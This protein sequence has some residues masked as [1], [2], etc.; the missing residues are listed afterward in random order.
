MSKRIAV[1]VFPG[2]NSECETVRILAQCG[3][4]AHLV[5]WSRASLLPA[6]DAYVLPGGFAYEDRI[7]AGAIA[8]HD[9]MMDHV[10][11]GAQGGK[12][13]LG[14]CNGAQILLEAGLVPGTGELR[15]PTAAFTRNGPVP[16]F[17]CAHVHVKLSVKPARSAITAALR[18]DALIPAWAAN[19]EGRLAADAPHL[20]E[21]RSGDH[22]AFVYAHEDGSVDE[23]ASPNQSALGAAALVN[24][25]GNVLAIMP[26][27][28]R[29]AWTFNHPDQRRGDAML[30][31]SGGDLLFRS[32][33]EGVRRV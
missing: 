7:R 4:D 9:A 22:V 24:R 25:E 2:T 33:V 6:F 10:I 18:H 17:V 29:D 8:A 20:E 23:S 28:E 15:R 11:A 21:L 19:G 13:V 12:L 26:H 27:P 3:G 30:A 32:F 14:I 5:H 31:T 16:H 1:L